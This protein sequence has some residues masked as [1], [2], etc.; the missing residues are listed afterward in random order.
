MPVTTNPGQTSKQY[1]GQMLKL[2]N[3]HFKSLAELLLIYAESSNL[4]FFASLLFTEY[5]FIFEIS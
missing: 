3:K 1:L 5:P 4:N 2:P